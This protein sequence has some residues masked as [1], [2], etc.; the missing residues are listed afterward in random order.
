MRVLCWFSCGDASAVATALALKK[1]R[2]THEVV[3]A[4]IRITSEHEDNDRF[5]VDCAK[6]FNAPIVT[7]SSPDYVDTWDVWEKTGYIAGIHGA[8]CTTKLKKEVRRAFQRPDDLHIFGYTYDERGRVKEFRENN[9]EL[10]VEFPLV[11]QFL[12][13]P[14]CHSLV[15]AAGIEIPVMYTLGFDNSNCIG[16]PK[17]GAG[18]WNMIR[19]HFPEVFRRMCELS[20]RLGVRL[21]NLGGVRMFLDELDPSV[22]K[23]KDEPVITCSAFCNAIEAQIT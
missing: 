2:D 11:E 22:G 15:Q 10:N 8:P 18:Y 19:V 17:G 16:C 20:R 5:A 13:K 23:Q 9:I 3:V 7:L 21:I 1:Y 12:S 14:D 4:R 6:W